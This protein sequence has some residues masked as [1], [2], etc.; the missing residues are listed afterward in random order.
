MITNYRGG[1]VVGS[2]ALQTSVAGEEIVPS[3]TK[4]VINFELL[5]D[6]NCTISLNGQ[7]AIF[8]RA[9]QGIKIPIV[10]SC[11]IIEADI[12]FNWTGISG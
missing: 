3:T 12:T 7:D 11:K 4:T 2:P 1:R 10:N 9:S 5:N 8:V 6:Q